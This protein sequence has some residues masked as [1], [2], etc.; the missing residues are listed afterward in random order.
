MTQK[1]LYSY[2][3]LESTKTGASQYLGTLTLYSYLNLESTKTGYS[4]I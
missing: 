2:L 3:N 4:I 1:G